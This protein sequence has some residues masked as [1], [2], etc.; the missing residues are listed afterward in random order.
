MY[1]FGVCIFIYSR[2]PS[3]DRKVKCILLNVFYAWQKSK[4]IEEENKQTATT[5]WINNKI[6]YRCV[7]DIVFY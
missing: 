1:D 2:K 3:A 6:R 4:S 7:R 5:K